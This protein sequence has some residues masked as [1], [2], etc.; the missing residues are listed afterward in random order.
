VFPASIGSGSSSQEGL[1]TVPPGFSRGLR[2]PGEETDDHTLVDLEDASNYDRREEEEVHN[3]NV[4]IIVHA[5][6]LPRT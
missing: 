6:A 4:N 3:S 1:R 2:L 5:L